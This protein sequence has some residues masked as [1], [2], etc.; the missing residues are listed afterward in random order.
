MNDKK[1]KKN[2]STVTIYDLSTTRY[3]PANVRR[4]GGQGGGYER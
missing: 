3:V 2:Y 1:Q 4:G